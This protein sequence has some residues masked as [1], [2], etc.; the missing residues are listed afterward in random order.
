M[1]RFDSPIGSTPHVC[2]VHPRS[3]DPHYHDPAAV[4]RRNLRGA[5]LGEAMI[6]TGVSTARAACVSDGH[7][8]AAA[9]ADAEVGGRLTFVRP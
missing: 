2:F 6:A 8:D 5:I 4:A 7:D 1:D 9:A 3:R